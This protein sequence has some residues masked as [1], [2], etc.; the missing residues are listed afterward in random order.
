MPLLATINIGDTI[1]QHHVIEELSDREKEIALNKFNS[2][3]N[4][5]LLVGEFSDNIWIINNETNSVSLTFDFSE[6]A[7]HRQKATSY[8]EFVLSVK[9]YICLCF[10]DYT[11][12]MFPRILNS[13]KK[14]VI[15]TNYFTTWPI[16]TKNLQCFGVNNFLGLLS[17]VD[18][19]YILPLI[20]NDY[21]NKRQRTLAEYRSYFIFNDLLEDFWKSATEDEKNFYYPIYLWWKISMILPL[22]VTEFSVIPKNCLDVKKKGQ[23]TIRRTIL[24]GK[25]QIK[26][27]YKLDTDYKF[28]HYKITNEIYEAISDYKNRTKQFGMAEIDS[29]FSD[30][31]YAEAKKILFPQYKNNKKTIFPHLRVSHL[32]TI[33]DIF[34]AQV[35]EK[36]YHYSI[37]VKGDTSVSDENG[38]IHELK[39][40]E[41]VMLD[42]GD[43]RHVA[44][45]N[46]LLN[47][48]DILMSREISGHE[49]VDM[50]F[51]YAGNM[52]NLI[53]CKAYS[54]F[55]LSKNKTNVIG[56]I[57][58]NN[59][60][61][62]LREKINGPGMQ[63]DDGVCHSSEMVIK[64]NANDC[65]AVGGDCS[66]CAFYENETDSEDICH[67]IEEEFKEKAARIRIWL[68]SAKKLKDKEQIMIAAEEMVAAANNLEIAYYNKLKSGGKI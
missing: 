8:K 47:G 63:L 3:K 41:I 23:L 68:N 28:Y 2:M 60:E 16:D 33:L 29:L 56:L 44:I 37:R 61:K 5:G 32:D 42:L 27:R 62:I 40:N 9:Y 57:M 66:I 38:E 55:E 30:K 6:I 65:F 50:I 4:N 67:E 7:I 21:E 20:D 45:Q 35:I 59:A 22:R 31:M 19:K 48:C 18:G 49:T 53:K 1:Q 12:V 26:E 17:W 15:D 52:K 24:K 43:T 10:G 46:L 36:K 58:S 14:S 34:F 64:H 25:S 54:L 13:I 11:L 39:P 51:H